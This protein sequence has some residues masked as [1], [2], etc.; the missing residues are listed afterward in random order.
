MIVHRLGRGDG[1]EQDRLPGGQACKGVRNHGPDRVKGEALEGVV[2]Q[3][4][5]RVRDVE[6]V[7]P[8]VNVAVQELVDVCVAVNGGGTTSQS[9]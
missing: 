8:A 9:L 2:V 6:A 3:R 7:V 4:A 5:E 1:K